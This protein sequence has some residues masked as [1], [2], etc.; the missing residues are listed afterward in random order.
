MQFKE[1]L[2]DAKNFKIKEMDALKRYASENGG[3]FHQVDKQPK[4]KL[5]FTDGTDQKITISKGTV[6]YTLTAG[7]KRRSFKDFNSL[8]KFLQDET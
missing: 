7:D 8:V 5:S 1:L 4:V 3:H 2:L 6:M